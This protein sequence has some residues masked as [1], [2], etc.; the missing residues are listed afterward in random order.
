MLSIYTAAAE[1]THPLVAFWPKTCHLWSVEEN[2]MPC[3]TLMQK[4][5]HVLKEDTGHDRVLQERRRGCAAM[6]F[7]RTREGGVS[8]EWITIGEKA[9]VRIRT[10]GWVEFVFCLIDIR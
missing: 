4:E 7:G 10:N 1:T 5:E 6:S 8:S 2:M 9:E 3:S